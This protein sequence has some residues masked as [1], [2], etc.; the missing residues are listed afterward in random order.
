[1]GTMEEPEYLRL[2]D[3]RIDLAEEEE[4]LKA[5]IA[6]SR[7]EVERML[8][9]MLAELQSQIIAVQAGMFEYLTA[10]TYTN[11]L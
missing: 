11:P 6:D 5:K 8:R 2:C 9:D 3:L 7:G 4:D 1:M 10:Q